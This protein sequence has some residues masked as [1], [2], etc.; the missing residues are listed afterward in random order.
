MEFNHFGSSK[1]EDSNTFGFNRNES[2]HF[3]I[4]HSSIHDSKHKSDFHSSIH[5]HKRIHESSHFGKDNVRSPLNHK[6]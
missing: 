2:K 4:S 6:N 3:G 1:K 5:D